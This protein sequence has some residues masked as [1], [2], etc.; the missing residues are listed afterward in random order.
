[1]KQLFIESLKCLKLGNRGLNSQQQ[2]FTKK[3]F[4]KLS[5]TEK[6]AMG[7]SCQLKISPDGVLKDE[8]T[9]N[10]F[11]GKTWTIRKLYKFNEKIKLELFEN[12]LNVGDFEISPNLVFRGTL[13]FNNNGADYQLIYIVA[14]PSPEPDTVAE[15]I[16]NFKDSTA[17]TKWSWINKSKLIED[18]ESIVADPYEVK[19]QYTPF[20]GPA[21]IVFELVSRDP[22]KYVEIMQS[23]YE[24]GQFRTRDGTIIESRE[25]LLKSR[26]PD[27]IRRANWM[28]LG[29]M[30][31]DENWLLAVESEGD[32]DNPSGVVGMTTIHEMK[33]WTES[34]LGFKNAKWKSSYVIGELKAIVKAQEVVDNGGVAFLLIDSALLNNR[35]PLISVPKHWIPYLGNLNMNR[36]RWWRVYDGRIEFDVF[37]W[38]EKF[39]V[40]EYASKLRHLIWGV[41]IAE[42]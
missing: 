4:F 21:S 42:P 20:C 30:R 6:L 9:N 13:E 26:V 17:S 11:P 40:D 35:N 18:I 23:I 5:P 7:Q 36:R 32:N 15:A 24:T 14:P 22:I 29:T 31:D 19:Q 3:I 1:M 16:Q 12:E 10:M 25:K 28:L 38:G 8:I 27:L 37:S 2:N 34:I 41:V 39:H 33:K